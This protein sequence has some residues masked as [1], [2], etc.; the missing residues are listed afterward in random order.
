MQ[1][2]QNCLTH[3]VAFY[4][5]EFS[6]DRRGNYQP[7]DIAF[8]FFRDPKVVDITVHHDPKQRIM[9][10]VV[11]DKFISEKAT[12]YY[13]EPVT[14]V[15]GVTRLGMKVPILAV[16]DAIPS[17]YGQGR[18]NK[19]VEMSNVIIKDM[20]ELKVVIIRT[21][22]RCTGVHISDI[23]NM[24]SDR[25]VKFWTHHLHNMMWGDARINPH[26][27]NLWLKAEMVEQD[28]INLLGLKIPIQIEA[29]SNSF[30]EISNVVA[31]MTTVYEEKWD[32]QELWK[33]FRTIQPL[34]SAQLMFATSER[35]R[36]LMMVMVEVSWRKDS[37]MACPMKTVGYDNGKMYE[38]PTLNRC[39]LEY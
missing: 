1:N 2:M 3:N 15:R 35:L 26:I 9:G 11:N 4:P 23:E 25:N 38:W 28:M 13:L 30:E 34:R 36:L 6:T 21:N 12:S 22:T 29:D 37:M 7:I 8:K 32:R 16:L 33:L 20:M 17:T 5:P 10:A 27:R 39:H 14:D 31:F 24:F 19:Y 18:W